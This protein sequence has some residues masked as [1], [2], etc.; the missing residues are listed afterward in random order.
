MREKDR[1]RAYNSHRDWLFFPPLFVVETCE[2]SSKRAITP[3]VIQLTLCVSR[4]LSQHLRFESPPPGRGARAFQ[5]QDSFGRTTQ[6]NIHSFIHAHLLC[7]CQK[8]KHELWRVKSASM[9]CINTA[10]PK[11]WPKTPLRLFLRGCP[12]NYQKETFMFLFSIFCSV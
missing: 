2:V 7:L 4:V 8:S 1:D 10:D 5:S 12:Y 11:T 6:P 9:P 3:F